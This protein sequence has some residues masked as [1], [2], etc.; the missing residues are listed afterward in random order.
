MNE[1]KYPKGT[2]K[3]KSSNICVYI[4][5]V[6]I[7]H[8]FSSSETIRSTCRYCILLSGYSIARD[9]TIT[10][11]HFFIRIDTIIVVSILHVAFSQ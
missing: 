9:L 6:H 1:T 7:L 11:Y 8:R 3:H 4:S 10:I 2:V 5:A